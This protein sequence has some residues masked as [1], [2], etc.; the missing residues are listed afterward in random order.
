MEVLRVDDWKK[1]L[2]EH[3][4][5]FAPFWEAAAEGR[6]LFQECPVCGN[7]QFYPRP[8]CLA[9]GADPTWVE[10]SGHGTV[11]TFTVVRQFGAP[12]FK[13]E[14]PYVVAVIELDEGVKMMGNVTG[15]PVDAVS[16]GMAVEAYANLAAERV[17]IPNWRPLGGR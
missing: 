8:L 12:P 17:G 4:P 5:V 11:H 14:L 15:C 10:A 16:V 2:P 9:C 13:D 3:D 1:P 6:L 7:R